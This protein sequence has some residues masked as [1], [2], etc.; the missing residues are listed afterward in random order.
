MPD[1]GSD[2]FLAN[3]FNQFFLV[4]SDVYTNPNP[5]P[6]YL[7]LTE[8]PHFEVIRSKWSFPGPG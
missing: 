2:A 1:M 8:V 6:P 5:H 4:K 7:L 3:I